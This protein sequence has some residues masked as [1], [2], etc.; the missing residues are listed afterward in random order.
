[1][2]FLKK[3]FSILI[4]PV[5]NEVIWIFIQCN[6]CSAKVKIRINPKTDLTPDYDA[7]SG[8]YR[9]HKEAMDAKCYSLIHI[10]MQLDRNY[11]IISQDIDGGKFINPEEYNK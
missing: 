1:M 2:S 11:R 9:L 5:R 4:P 3:I 8:Y 7:G 6:K 10:R